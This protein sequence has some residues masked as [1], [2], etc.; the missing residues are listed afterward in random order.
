MPPYNDAVPSDDFIF[1]C[2]WV[3]N[4]P[5]SSQSDTRYRHS[6]DPF[7][8]QSRSNVG[9][10]A[11]QNYS[12]SM[13]DS[14]PGSQLDVE[15]RY[16]SESKEAGQLEASLDLT[17]S[18]E[19]R[20]FSDPGIHDE[21]ENRLHG[22]DHGQNQP[23]NQ[24]PNLQFVGQNKQN[25][26]A[27][28]HGI[29][30]NSSQRPPA[31]SEAMQ[32]GPLKGIGSGLPLPAS[33][34]PERVIINQQ[35]QSILWPHNNRQY[36]AGL[37]GQQL[38]QNSDYPLPNIHKRTR[39]SYLQQQSGSCQI[40]ANVDLDE[41]I[42]RNWGGNCIADDTDQSYPYHVQTPSR[43]RESSSKGPWSP[44]GIGGGNRLIPV[45]VAIYAHRRNIVASEDSISG[46]NSS[47]GISSLPTDRNE[48]T[49]T[50]SLDTPSTDIGASDGT[51][52][53]MSRARDGVNLDVGQV[54]HLT[55]TPSTPY[56]ERDT[57][58]V[59]QSHEHCPISE[60]WAGQRRL[61]HSQFNDGAYAM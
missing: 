35:G 55:E 27:Q 15:Y 52:R 42:K 13:D 44:E 3:Y 61:N 43:G 36:N 59:S 20:S 19:Y 37:S 28:R 58:N 49:P 25:L 16:S 17:H 48:A 47:H 33:P 34:R 51:Q 9:L 46:R 22:A 24:H 5:S 54:A 50:S 2:G 10:E 45:P 32:T 8:N 30:A 21:F 1:T 38:D 6:Q 12:H 4:E 60:A 39:S 7:E 14:A 41:N 23:T 11:I 53:P 18:T 40:L 31:V 26:S 56:Y 29:I 57:P